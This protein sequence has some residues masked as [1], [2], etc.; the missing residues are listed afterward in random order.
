M[1]LTDLTLLTVTFNNN[2]LTCMMIRSFFKQVSPIKVVIIDNGTTE[3]CDAALKKIFQVIDNTNQKITGDYKQCSKNHCSSIDYALKHVITTDWA[4]LVDNDVLFKP[5]VNPYLQSFDTT[6]YDCAGE[7]GWDDAP[8][9]RL[10]PYFCLINVKKFNQQHKSYFDNNRCIGP[11]SKVVGPRGKSSP[12]W[13]KDTGCSFYE[14][15]QASW[16][17]HQIE[18]SNVICHMKGTRLGHM[19][20]TDFLDTYKPLWE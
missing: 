5:A 10:F 17:I 20:M 11:G 16:S 1:K 9:D 12:C 8:P 4:L 13:Y 6:R 15:I 7:I 18:L 2:I 3:P 14:D 19:S